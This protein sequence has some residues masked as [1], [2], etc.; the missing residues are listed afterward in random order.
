MSSILKFTEHSFSTLVENLVISK[1]MTYIEA[2]L[3]LCEQENIEP[4]A[5]VS[6]LSIPIKEKLKIEGQ[7][8]NIIKKS[9]PPLSFL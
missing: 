6:L 4:D 8:I 7:E 2:V 1:N 9:T 3:Y 5:V